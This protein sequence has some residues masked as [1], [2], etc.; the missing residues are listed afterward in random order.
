RRGEGNEPKVMHVIGEVDGRT[1]LIVD[2]I[3]DTAGTLAGTVQALTRKGAKG[4][5]GCFTHAVLSG[6]A[7]DRIRASEMMQTVVT[8]TIPIDEEKRRAGR[9]TVLS[10]A[11]LL[12]EAIKRIHTNSSVSSLFV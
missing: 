6:P 1:C 8:N 5:Y 2:D 12:G 7:V 4:I 3:V 9:I 11:G 10:V